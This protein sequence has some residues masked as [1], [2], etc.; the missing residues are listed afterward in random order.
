MHLVRNI[1]RQFARSNREKDAQNLVAQLPL[2]KRSLEEVG[3]N[4]R[5]CRQSGSTWRKKSEIETKLGNCHENTLTKTLM[6]RQI[7]VDLV[8]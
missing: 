1:Q 3:R 8:P 2:T 6:S 7:Q 4:D 5:G